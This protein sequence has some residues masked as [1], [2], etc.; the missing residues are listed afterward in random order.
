M[1]NLIEWAKKSGGKMNGFKVR[2]YSET[3]RGIIATKD[4]KIGDSILTL[5]NN[6]IIDIA[7]LEQTERGKLLK[8]EYKKIDNL[9]KGDK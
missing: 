6:L 5:P 7:Y 2:W 3:N 4:F 9:M 1:N 8:S